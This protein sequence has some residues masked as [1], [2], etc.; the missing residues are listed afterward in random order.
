MVLVEPSI[1]ILWKNTNRTK[2][3]SFRSWILSSFRLRQKPCS[4]RTAAWPVPWEQTSREPER[5]WPPLRSGTL[6]LDSCRGLEELLAWHFAGLVLRTLLLF[7][8]TNQILQGN[9]RLDRFSLRRIHSDVCLSLVA[10]CHNLWKLRPLCAAVGHFSEES[11]S[12]WILQVLTE[13]SLHLP[14]KG[15]R[16]LKYSFSS[17]KTA[18]CSHRRNYI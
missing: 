3:S 6:A 13:R 18:Q 16:W 7:W 10:F 2:P 1:R 5:P 14:N 15:E 9:L 4:S 12:L 8:K 17:T 11:Q